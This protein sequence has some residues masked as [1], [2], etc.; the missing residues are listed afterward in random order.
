MIPV[1]LDPYMGESFLSTST[2]AILFNI[3]INLAS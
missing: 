3:L 1:L 2:I